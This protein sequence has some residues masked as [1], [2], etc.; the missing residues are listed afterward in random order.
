MPWGTGGSR[1][2]EHDW[3]LRYQRGGEGAGQLPPRVLGDGTLCCPDGD[4]MFILVSSSPP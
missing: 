2:I 3:V 4:F 1:V